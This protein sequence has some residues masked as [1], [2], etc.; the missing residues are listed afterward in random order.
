MYAC[1][2][3]YPQRCTRVIHFTLNDVRVPQIDKLSAWSSVLWLVVG[4]PLHPLVW[5]LRL[6]LNNRVRS[7]LIFKIHIF[8]LN[9]ALCE[10]QFNFQMQSFNVKKALCSFPTQVVFANVVSSVGSDPE[11]ELWESYTVTDETTIA[12]ISLGLWV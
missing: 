9:T 5:T 11:I 10:K 3:L 4:E 8:L 2:S 6:P 12:T 1:N 7:V